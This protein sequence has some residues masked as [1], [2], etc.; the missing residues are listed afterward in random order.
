MRA[1]RFASGFRG[2]DRRAWL[3]TIVRNVCYTQLSR[4]TAASN[5]VFD[6]E[7]HQGA[8]PASDP[9]A[10]AFAASIARR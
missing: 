10:A 8:R 7:Q 5:V 4:R 1:M 9:Q 6:E 2:G 3:L